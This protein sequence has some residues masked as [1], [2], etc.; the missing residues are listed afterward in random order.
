MPDSAVDPDSLE[1][2]SPPAT[3]NLFPALQ[4][5]R[6]LDP[7]KAFLDCLVPQRTVCSPVLCWMMLFSVKQTSEELATLSSL[8]PNFPG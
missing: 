2:V 8:E 6:C 7:E 1:N 3:F 5:S 4:I